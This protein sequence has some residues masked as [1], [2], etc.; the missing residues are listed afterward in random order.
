MA[1]GCV[2]DL[3]RDHDDSQFL[4]RTSSLFCALIVCDLIKVL[5]ADIALAYHAHAVRGGDE[6]PDP[7][8]VYAN[9]ASVPSLI[10]GGGLVACGRRCLGKKRSV[11]TGCDASYIRE[12]SI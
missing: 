1:A 6:F 8:A 9:I 3:L 7:F 10:K 5:G 2:C 12:R 11:P 4:L